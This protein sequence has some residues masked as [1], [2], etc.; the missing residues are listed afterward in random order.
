MNISLNPFNIFKPSPVA[1]KILDDLDKYPLPDWDDYHIYFKH[2][3]LSY[4]IHLTLY[5]CHEVCGLEL[6][7]FDS[8][9]VDSKCKS[10]IK[11]AE[12]LARDMKQVMVI[13]QILK[14]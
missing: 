1:Q 11:A 9:R 13:S 3:K 5:C 6:G 7:Y 8:K 14:S 2:P 4:Q 10:Q 12:K